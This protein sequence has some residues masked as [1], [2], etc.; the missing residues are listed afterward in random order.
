MHGSCHQEWRVHHKVCDV[1]IEYEKTVNLKTL[2]SLW[3]DYF[4]LESLHQ[5]M[6][7]IIKCATI[8]FFFSA[9]VV[10]CFVKQ[11]KIAID[12]CKVGV[13]FSHD[14]IML[15]CQD[16]KGWHPCTH[17]VLYWSHSMCCCK[18]STRNLKLSLSPYTVLLYC[19]IMW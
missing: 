8:I 4:I 19:M 15:L 16:N 3:L 5:L 2:C 13:S 10:C 14:V 17:W 6:K 9:W 18:L 12:H 7:P 11:E 1:A